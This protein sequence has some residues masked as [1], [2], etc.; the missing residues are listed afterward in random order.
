VLGL[1]RQA[2]GQTMALLQIGSGRTASV[3][4][5]W[6]GP[7]NDAGTVSAAVS[8]APGG[9]RSISI[10]ANGDAGLVLAGGRAETIAGPGSNWQALPPLPANAAT[11]ALATTGQLEALTAQRTLFTVWRLAAGDGSWSE[12]QQIKVAIPYGSSG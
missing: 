2:A 12:V 4:A 8:V 11:L 6:L 3:A 1:A 5:A 9:P 10:W 7:A